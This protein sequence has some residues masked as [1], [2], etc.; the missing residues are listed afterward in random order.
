MCDDLT[1]ARGGQ[2]GEPSTQKH[3]TL[4]QITKS[5][6]FNCSKVDNTVPEPSKMVSKVGD[7]ALG[8]VVAAAPGLAGRTLTSTGTGS[9]IRNRLLH[10]GLNLSVI[11]DLSPGVLLLSNSSR[12]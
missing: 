6:R 11:L 7:V 1:D 10:I 3:N 5:V 2:R 8:G 4:K 9:I 12:C